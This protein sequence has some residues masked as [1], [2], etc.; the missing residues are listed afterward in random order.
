[1]KSTSKYI[2]FEVET[3]MSP[4]G[5]FGGATS[6]GDSSD[7]ES[8]PGDYEVATEDDLMQLGKILGGGI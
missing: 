8:S 7:S 6:K 5:L 3:R 2:Q 4:F 1:M